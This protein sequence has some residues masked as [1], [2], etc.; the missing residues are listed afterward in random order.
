M[1]GMQ[2]KILCAHCGEELHWGDAACASCGVIID[3][4]KEFGVI[5]SAVTKQQPS[6]SSKQK[7]ASGILSSKLILGVIIGVAVAVVGYEIFFDKHAAVAPVTA[8]PLAATVQAMQQI[9]DLEKQLQANPNNS[10]V[11]LELANLFHDNMMWNKAITH[12]KSY[13]NTNSKDA[14]AR[15]DLG[16][17]YKESNDLPEAKQQ[18]QEALKYD[19]KH[20]L[21][22][23]NLGIVALTE[24][25][26]EESNK[27]FK[28][29]I[30]LAP[31]SDVG[32]RAQQLIE[33]HS[34]Q[35]ITL[36]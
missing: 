7:N 18:M 10:A 12:Y 22:H 36:K 19:P 13:L 34:S 2:P 8:Q 1:A 35:P 26:L 16:I 32:K 21:A 4:P 15:V 9:Q 14:N 11:E 23:F 3:W 28:K 27:W 17:C 30:E 33:Q 24:G 5:A 6:Q 29:T 31:N 20:V 25:N